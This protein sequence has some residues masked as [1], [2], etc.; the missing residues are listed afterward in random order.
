[1]PLTLDEI[2]G[3]LTRRGA[4]QY[5]GEAVSQ[6]EHALQC[7]HLAEQAGEPDA[8]VVAALLHDIGHLLRA[9]APGALHDDRHQE[10]ALPFLRGLLPDSVLEPIR[11]HVAAKRYLCQAD[12]QYHASLTPASRR[13]LEL[14]GGIFDATQARDFLSQ[15]HAAEAV[16]LRR[17]DDLAKVAGLAV[18]ELAHYA[19]RLKQ[20]TL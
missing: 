16:R 8:V 18:P 9:E 17:Y 20:A 12:A 13:S 15:P 6:L 4:A 1:M 3:V 10:L 11:L 19:G 2:T 7:A 5:G 14:Q